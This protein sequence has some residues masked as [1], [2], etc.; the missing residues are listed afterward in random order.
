MLRRSWPAGLQ[1]EV[2]NRIVTAVRKIV[3]L[4]RYA[5]LHLEA[6]KR[7]KPAAL[8]EELGCKRYRRASWEAAQTEK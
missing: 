1:L 7:I 5:G 3:L 6:A 2:A 4:L 8:R